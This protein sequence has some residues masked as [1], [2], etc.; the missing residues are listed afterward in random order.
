M[1]YTYA[2]ILAKVIAAGDLFAQS[3]TTLSGTY[4][5]D[6]KPYQDAVLKL[7]FKDFKDQSLQNTITATAANPGV[8]LLLGINKQ[9]IGDS[10]SDTNHGSV[11]MDSERVVINAKDDF[12]FL[13]GSTGVA[14]G[15]PNR[16]NIDSGQSITLFAHDKLLLGVPNRGLPI[17]S[18]AQVAAGETT[19]GDPTLDQEY[20]P[21]VL[22]IKL[23]NL[24]EDILFF[25]KK[26]DLVSGISPVRFQPSTLAEFAMLA[27][28]IPEMLSTYAYVDGFSHEEINQSTLNQLKEAQK[29]AKNYTPPTQITGSV[30]GVATVGP[31]PGGD[32]SNI[33]GPGFEPMKH[34]IFSGESANYDAMYPSTTYAKAVGNG[35]PC[36]K[37]TIAEVA[38][39]ATGAIGRYQNLP[40]YLI[41]R[42]QIAKLD[43]N[44]A[45]YNDQ[46]QEKMGETLI[47]ETVGA[48]IQGKN[49]GSRDNLID[50]VQALGRCWASL[51]VVKNEDKTIVGDVDTGASTYMRSGSPT[52]GGFYS[53]S[54]ANAYG[55]IKSKTVK[56]VVLT[57]L[58]TR[59]NLGTKPEFIP[60]YAN[61]DTL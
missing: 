15:S 19:K 13:L 29:K 57:L 41:N 37:K 56:D 27:N 47:I 30:T 51:P 11:I 43:P 7:D 26:A 16:V 58:K 40:K 12:A 31:G 21:L 36:M 6:L 8:D 1:K 35:V 24:L 53:K 48:Y 32:Y 39:T 59:K 60:T 52:G 4:E 45:L 54:K 46:N 61:W 9:G 33:G 3:T 28:R 22:G 42:A 23:A 34:L 49:K 5:I 38:R 2:D 18:T 55:V 50:A 14:L 17:K 25:L 20:E 44:T 10:L